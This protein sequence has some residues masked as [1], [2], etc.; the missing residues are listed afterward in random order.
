ME[1]I[2]D[3]C[4]VF[5]ENNLKNDTFFL[6]CCK[7][8][9]LDLLKWILHY[10][11]EIN[12]SDNEN[13]GYYVA[14]ESNNLDVAK[15]LYNK[16]PNNNVNNTEYILE[17]CCKNGFEELLDWILNN[18]RNNLDNFNFN[19]LFSQ[20][21]I[22]KNYESAKI[23]FK[24][25]KDIIINNDNDNLFRDAC[26]E[27]NIKLVNLLLHIRPNA[28]FVNIIDDKIVHYEILKSLIV[29]NSISKKE[30]SRIEDCYICYSKS[31]IF[32][33]CKHFYCFDCL[34]KYYSYNNSNCPYCRN[35]INEWNLFNIK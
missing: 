30:I 26:N 9:N 24:Y 10:D 3:L 6:L 21:I 25:S 23:I 12:I 29:E 28:Y 32:T 17:V 33:S 14:C 13:L 7:T 27:N 35:Q 19:I 2:I 22:N 4:T 8:G 34:E 5:E 31:N 16:S 18:N 20:C 15:W 1:D 11:Y